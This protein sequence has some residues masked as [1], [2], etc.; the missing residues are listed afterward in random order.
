MPIPNHCLRSRGQRKIAVIAFKIDPI[1]PPCHDMRR[2]CRTAAVVS[3]KSID[4]TGYIPWLNDV[5]AVIIG[6]IAPCTE[7]KIDLAI[8]IF[9]VG[10]DARLPHHFLAEH[11]LA[12]P[13]LQEAVAEIKLGI[14]PFRSA[15]AS[16]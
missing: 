1:G 14:N 16:N 7:L 11:R 10:V 8:V 9:G 4:I 12:M 15:P 13:V 3:I 6:R 2:C 5:L